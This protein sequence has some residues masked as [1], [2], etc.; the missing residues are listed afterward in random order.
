ML[1]G[2]ASCATASRARAPTRCAPPAPSTG[3]SAGTQARRHGPARRARASSR[4][5]RDRRATGGAAARRVASHR[6]PNRVL[7]RRYW[8]LA[9]FLS[10]RAPR[11]RR[12][13]QER[14]PRTDLKTEA[15]GQHGGH[16]PAPRKHSPKNRPPRRLPPQNSLRRRP[17][18]HLSH[19][20]VMASGGSAASHG[21]RNSSRWAGRVALPGLLL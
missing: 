10:F 16:C 18:P 17:A 4:R 2:G 21:K 3:C 12:R 11:P 6:L 19:C 5:T 14:A 13:A 1:M 9:G 8:P 7:A 20:G 15:S